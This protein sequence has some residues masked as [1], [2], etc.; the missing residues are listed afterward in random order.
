MMRS[1]QV[2]SILKDE[3]NI[4]VLESHFTASDYFHVTLDDS[5]LTSTTIAVLMKKYRLSFFVTL[6]DNNI[7]LGFFGVGK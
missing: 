2:L 1:S 4:D 7:H 6:R 3:L 5:M